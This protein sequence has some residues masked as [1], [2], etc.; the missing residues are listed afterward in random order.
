VKS[1][2]ETYNYGRIVLPA[3]SQNRTLNIYHTGTSATIEFEREP[4]SG[5]AVTRNFALSNTSVTRDRTVAIAFVIPVRNDAVRLSRCLDSIVRNHYPRTS[6]EV[7]VIDNESTD[8]SGEVARASADAVIRVSGTSVAALRNR[9][10][11]ETSAPLIAFV[12]A[13]HEIHRDWIGAAVTTLADPAV[14]AAGFPYDTQPDANWVQRLYDAMRR[15]PL[16]RDTVSWL[17]SGNL[18]VKRTCFDAIGGF[19]ESLIA[20]EDVDLC[21]R[22]IQAGYSI[23]ADPR[24]R[25]THYGDPQTV[26]S[27][28]LGELWRGRDNLRVTFSG[29]RTLRHLRSALLQSSTCSV[30][31]AGSSHWW[32]VI[33]WSRSRCGSS[34]S[35][36]QC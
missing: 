27:L 3:A 6:I 19:R 12:D 18:V 15:R 8:N 34:R 35:W 14:G 20:C 31:P 9:G 5:R 36:R 17:G 11:R 4:R 1:N 16:S 32:P 2:D 28:F 22:L 24:M 13:D 25:S 21:N 10:A 30:S 29:P 23:V 26:R 33:R 7:L